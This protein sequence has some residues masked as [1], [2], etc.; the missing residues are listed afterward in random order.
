MGVKKGA[1]G[2]VSKGSEVED[3]GEIEMW[4]DGEQTRSF[5]YIDECIEA[6]RR[7]VESDFSGPVN[8]GSDEMISINGLAK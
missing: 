3:G 6:V 1:R 5:L 8:I 7:L 4:G 2:Y